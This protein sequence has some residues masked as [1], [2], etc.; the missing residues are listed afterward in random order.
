MYNVKSYKVPILCGIKVDNNKVTFNWDTDD[1]NDVIHLCQNTSGE[2][3]DDGVRYFYGYSY[4][5]Q[6]SRAHRKIVRQ[7]LKNLDSSSNLYSDDEWEFI[8]NGL[9]HLD[10]KYPISN[11]SVVVSVDS[12]SKSSLVDMINYQMEDFIS[13]E[14]YWVDI[15]LVK[16]TYADVKFNEEMLRDILKSNYH[17]TDNRINYAVNK[18]TETFNSLKNSGEL[19]QMKRFVPK[20]IRQGF[21]NFLKFKN[22]EEKELYNS[23]QGV[24]VLLLDDFITSGATIKEMVRCLRSIHN[25]NRLTAFALVKQH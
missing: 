8:E 10:S 2:Y 16:A 18:A 4:D 21:T 5:I 23:L 17:W 13:S 7:Y 22:D 25:E 15:K 12:V 9:L 14:T 11:F 19:F 6:S 20:E 3:N 1:K 24:D